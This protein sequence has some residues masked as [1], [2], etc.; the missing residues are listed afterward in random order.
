MNYKE[1]LDRIHS[2]D[3]A[4]LKGCQENWNKVAK[5][6]HSLGLLEGLVAKIGAAQGTVHPDIAKRK[7]LVF[8]ADN[9]VVAEGVSQSASAV[10]TAVARSMAAGSSNVNVF[11][12]EA[13]AG[14]AVYDVGMIDDVPGL[15]QCKVCR[16]TRN[17]A[18]EPAMSRDEAIAAIEAGIHAAEK[19]KEEGCKLLVTGEMGIGNTTTAAAVLSV[20]TRTEPEAVCGRG[21][22]LSDAGFKRK[23]QAVR[24][25]IATNCPCPEDPV[26]V[27]AKV[28][29]ADIAAMCGVFL[30]G[31]ALQVPV[32]MD[33]LIS[34]VAALAAA[35]ID[36][37]TVEYMIPSH[38]GREP[39]GRL[40]L[41][42]L[43]LKAP[44]Q[45]DLALGE[46]TGGLLLLPMLDM[47]L[48]LY[49]SSHSFTDI[50][51]E[52]YR[53]QEGV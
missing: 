3:P 6:L 41:E 16:G 30:A 27:I 18:K 17:L 49:N 14:V 33:G 42:A 44:I 48:A 53:E 45:A 35:R 13:G 22:G 19:A 8:C 39:G 2:T 25:G 40:A 38:T 46:G 36:N 4:L 50:G 15:G 51:I 20:L 43:G 10:T 32:V 12:L 9:G 23:I 24:K 11:A 29:G 31:A 52:P 7:A 21:S 34:C 28:G 5:P 47:A 26:D 1:T 37:H